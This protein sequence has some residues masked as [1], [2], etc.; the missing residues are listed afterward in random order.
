MTSSDG[1]LSCQRPDNRGSG[2]QSLPII[3][4]TG[5]RMPRSPS[6]DKDFGTSCGGRTNVQQQPYA[7][8]AVVLNRVS[9][10]FPEKFFKR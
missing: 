10:S 9:S 1:G 5:C 3:M 6:R 4:A 8:T 2:G 7:T